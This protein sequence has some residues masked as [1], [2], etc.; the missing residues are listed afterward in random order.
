MSSGPPIATTLE[1]ANAINAALWAEVQALRE[2][3]R[4]LRA[5]LGKDSSNSSKP[6]STDAPWKGP[7]RKPPRLR[8]GLKRGAQP[9]HQA[10]R[11]AT[12]TDKD[13]SEV[14]DV[15]PESCDG[16]GTS[17]VGVEPC[18]VSGEIPLIDLPPI[19]VLVTLFRIW[20]TRCPCC[21]KRT[22]GTPPPGV[23]ESLYGPRIHA[24]VAMLVA[25]LRI[26]RDE[27]R[28]VPGSVFGVD[29][30]KGA[31]QACCV[32][33]SEAVAPAVE[34]IKADVAAAENVNLDETSWKEAGKLVWLRLAA[35]TTSVYYLIAP[36]RSRNE[37]DKL[38][39]ADFEGNA[40]TDRYAVYNV[41]DALSHQFCHSHLRRDFQ[42][43]IDRGGDGAPIGKKL[44]AASDALFHVW[45]RFKNGA[46]D[47]AAMRREMAPVRTTWRDV[48]NAGLASPD[49][50]VRRLCKT[51]LYYWPCLWIFWIDQGVEPTNNYAEQQMR[52]PVRWR[53]TCFG[54]QSSAGSL[55]AARML[56]V[57]ATAHR[58]GVD[59]LGWL[60]LALHAHLAQKPLPLLPQPA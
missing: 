13:A 24:L 30:S 53:R 44:L 3:V 17:L 43:V 19:E 56:S 7:K 37:L 39:P 48:F 32:R 6:P 47:W 28:T 14:V 15:R 46:T 4:E 20:R 36:T 50:R 16:C 51:L 21:G 41:L 59:A 38:L 23:G 60:T 26:S 10:H 8:S 1:E 29:I 5:R 31:V 18:E 27:V 35:T 54:T 42:A 55:F 22:T 58:R 40:T 2:E 34:A 52:P 49:K 11:H 12:L 33:A 25:R 57:F 9:G 45:H